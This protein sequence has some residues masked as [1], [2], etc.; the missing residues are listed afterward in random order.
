MRL[1]AKGPAAMELEHSFAI[2]IPV[3]DARDLLLDVDRTARCMPGLSVT[4]A[5]P[6]LMHA[7]VKVKVGPIRMAYAGTARLVSRDR[8]SGLVLVE[9]SGQETR[10]AGSASATIRLVLT[11]RGGATAVVVRTTLNLTGKPAQ[12]GRGVVQEIT[13][14]MVQQFAANL[15][16]MVAAGQ[17]GLARPQ[18][19]PRHGVRASTQTAGHVRANRHTRPM[20]ATPNPSPQ[21]STGLITQPRPARR[22]ARSSPSMGQTHCPARP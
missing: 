7:T 15:E 20:A 1:R 17:A 12:F 10:G 14:R 8:A 4:A 13:A 19:N 3:D 22:C 6:G 18:I 16:A 9:A 5:E 11:D 2:S 21:A